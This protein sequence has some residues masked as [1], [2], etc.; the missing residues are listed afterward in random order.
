MD[1][2]FNR[3]AEESILAIA[4]GQRVTLEEYRR[5]AALGQVGDSSGFEL[6]EGVVVAKSPQSLRHESALEKLQDV[7]RVVPEDW[8][9]R[10]QQ[11]LAL[12][13][14]QP[15]PDIAV[16]KRVLDGYVSAP[17]LGRDVVLVVE[18]AD[19]T[20]LNDRRLK[21]RIYSRAGILNFWVLNLLD[22]QLEV[23]S[24]PS[25]PVP[26]PGYQEHRIYRIEDRISLLIGLD[27]LGVIR[28]GDLIP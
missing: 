27:D 24:N 10:V 23:F 4:A 1:D 21:Q 18:A 9:I 3:P 19:A 5:R 25:G 8:M 22:S 13:D 6:L 11:S 28:V 16:V 26:M 12:G 7:L 17:P 15:E 14:S 20:L 2:E